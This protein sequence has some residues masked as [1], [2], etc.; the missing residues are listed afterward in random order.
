MTYFRLK[1][2]WI[3]LHK[4][5]GRVGASVKVIGTVCPFLPLSR[6][7]QKDIAAILFLSARYKGQEYWTVKLKITLLLCCYYCYCCCYYYYC[8]CCYYCYC[9]CCYCYCYYCYCY[10][11]YYFF[12]RWTKISLEETKLS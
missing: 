5:L 1:L 10:Y 8:C 4:P 3:Y 9:C 6:A 7:Y 2:Y 12:S 11:Y